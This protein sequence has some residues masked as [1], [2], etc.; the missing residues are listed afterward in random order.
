MNNAVVVHEL[1]EKGV[2]IRDL[3]V[4]VGPLVVL[5]VQV[6]VS[7]SRPLF[8]MTSWRTSW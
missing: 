7:G 3:F 8:P 4:T 2:I 1:I 6:T 5:T